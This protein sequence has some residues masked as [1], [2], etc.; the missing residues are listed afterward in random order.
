MS[1]EDAEMRE[2]RQGDTV[3]LRVNV[4]DPHEVQVVYAT[5][6]REGSYQGGDTQTNQIR[7]ESIPTER[8]PGPV[9]LELQA[10]VTTQTPGVYACQEIQAFDTLN[11]ESRTPLDPPRRFRI[12][13]SAEDDREGPEVSEV[14]E[15]R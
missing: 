15:F 1:A 2:Y 12:I 10:R 9:T 8:G 7:L 14:G 6:I 5:A 11:Q 4:Q 3:R 13:E